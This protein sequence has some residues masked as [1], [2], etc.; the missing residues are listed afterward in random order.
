[1]GFLEDFGGKLLK[2]KCV[3]G[4]AVSN[5]GAFEINNRWVRRI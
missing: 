2:E 4:R 1:M 5:Y 3:V